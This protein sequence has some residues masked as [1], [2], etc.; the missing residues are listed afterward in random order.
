MIQTLHR[1]TLIRGSG[2][3][4]QVDLLVLGFFVTLLWNCHHHGDMVC[5][6]TWRTCPHL[7]CHTD[8]QQRLVIM[9]A[10]NQD[11]KELPCPLLLLLE[12]QQMQYKRAFHVSVDFRWICRA[13]AELDLPP[14]KIYQTRVR[15]HVGKWACRFCLWQNCSLTH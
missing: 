8:H 4:A 3:W 2:K 13:L 12:Q 5:A 6:E 11:T 15:C 1:I 7:V 9:L 10:G 14:C